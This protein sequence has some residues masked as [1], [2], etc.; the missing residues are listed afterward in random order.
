M[1]RDWL[2]EMRL[3]S[4]GGNIWSTAIEELIARILKPPDTVS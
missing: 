3:E 1:S 4:R 2:L